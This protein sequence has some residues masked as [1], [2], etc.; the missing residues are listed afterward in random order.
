[1]DEQEEHKLELHIQ[2]E[3]AKFLKARGWHVERM[4][5]DPIRMAS[6]TYTIYHKQWGSIAG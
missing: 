3:L 5:A 4:L 6:P 2:H 1:M